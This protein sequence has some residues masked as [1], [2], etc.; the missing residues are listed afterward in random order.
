MIPENIILYHGWLFRILRAG[1]DFFELVISRHGG[2][3]TIGVR[4]VSAGGVLV[5]FK[6]W[7]FRR[8]Q[9]GVLASFFSFFGL[10][11]LNYFTVA[12]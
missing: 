5:G 7:N 11:Q 4:K 1:E 12:Q 9:T 3:V 8:R 10:N 2:I 6:I